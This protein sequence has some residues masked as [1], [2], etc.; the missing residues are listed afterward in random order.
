MSRYVKACSRTVRE[1][2]DKEHFHVVRDIRKVI[3]TIERLGKD[4]ESLDPPKFGEI[5]FIESTYK[6]NNRKY[7]EYLL[8]KDGFTLVVK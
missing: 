2:F 5:Y 7:P 4:S 8:T 6:D 3:K 1:M